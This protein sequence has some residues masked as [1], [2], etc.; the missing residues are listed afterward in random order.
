MTKQI[1]CRQLNCT[2]NDEDMH[3]MNKEI[4]EKYGNQKEMIT[5]VNFNKA[6]LSRKFIRE[7]QKHQLD[8]LELYNIIVKMMITMDR[9][10][11]E[12]DYYKIKSKEVKDEN[13]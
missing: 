5:C 6:L 7:A 10:E 9:I 12:R 2:W 3:C 11:S 13:K 8:H 1:K 4:L